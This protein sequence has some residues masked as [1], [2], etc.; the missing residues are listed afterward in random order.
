MLA[1]IKAKLAAFREKIRGWKTIIWN[2]IIAILPVA[3]VALDK[4]QAVDLSQFMTPWAAIGVGFLVSAVG[5]WLRTITTGPVG[6]TG[7]AEPAPNVKAG[8]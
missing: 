5:V 4:L 8:D 2:A 7:T 3:L 1:T 6:A